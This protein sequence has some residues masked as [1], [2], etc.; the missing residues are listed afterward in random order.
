MSETTLPKP[1][2]AYLGLL[3][4][5]LEDARGVDRS[6]LRAAACLPFAAA[7]QLFSVHKR[8]D[9]L[10]NQ[11]DVIIDVVV[12]MMRQR[13][14]M[15]TEEAAEWIGDEFATAR[16]RA[17]VAVSITTGV[18]RQV[19]DEI[20]GVAGR[21]ASTVVSLAGARANPNNGKLE[22]VAERIEDRIA[23]TSPLEPVAPPAEPTPL[24]RLEDF[25]VPPEVGAEAGGLKSADEL[26]LDDFDHMT[27]AQLRGRLRT[28]DRA[29]L[30]QLL[31]YERAHADRVGIVVM[32]ENR[33]SKLL[34]DEGPAAN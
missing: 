9:D 10:A 18:A 25:S 7:G 13:F 12:G 21:A 17:N 23:D 20:T 4:A 26:P 33:M 29:Q 5:T 15:G 11:G 32:L 30:V 28:L 8:Y 16:G 31:D 24:Q 27:A 1:L 3:V 34:A 19:S 14:G 2:S 6:A 22:Q